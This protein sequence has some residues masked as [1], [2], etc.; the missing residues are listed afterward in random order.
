MTGHISTLKLHQYRYN[1]LPSDGRFEVE[2]HLASCARC[3]ERLAVQQREREAFVAMP[4]PPAILGASA[5]R[6]ASWLRWL[7]PAGGLVAVAAAVLLAVGVP[8]SGKNHVKGHGHGDLEAL[9]ESP[10]GPRALH[11]GETVHA[12][13]VVQL[14]YDRE[15]ASHVWLAGRDGTG[16]VELYGEVPAGIDGLQPAP[17][18]LTLDGAP[19][20]QEFFAVRSDRALTEDEVK[21]AVQASVPP[22]GA[23]VA[24]LS[25]PKE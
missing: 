18:S 1:E 22:R 23:S 2:A 15:G 19:G 24:R 6:R 16:T 4:V 13:S 14:S 7:L 12:G 21:R 11:P 20:P 8:M 9:V 5:P 3:A 10:Q 25:L 17:F